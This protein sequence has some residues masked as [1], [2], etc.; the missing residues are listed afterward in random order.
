[1]TLPALREKALGSAGAEP[2]EPGKDSG[3]RGGLLAAS[4]ALCGSDP[5]LSR[6]ATLFEDR[7]PRV[8]HN[9]YRSAGLGGERHYVPLLIEKLGS[10][11]DRREAREA[12]ALYGDRIVG[13]L[14]DWL[15]DTSLPVAVRREIPRVLS[16]IGTQDAAYSLLRGADLREDRAVVHEVLRALNRIR[17]RDQALPAAVGGGRHL[18]PEIDL[19]LRLLVQRTSVRSI[20][21][22]AARTLLMHVLGEWIDQSLELIFRRLALLYPTREVLLAHRGAASSNARLRAQSLEVLDTILSAEHKGLLLPL[23]EDAP[24]EEKERRAARLLGLG[25]PS[26]RRTLQELIESEEPCI[27]A[28]EKQPAAVQRER[29][30]GL[31]PQS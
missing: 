24:A 6:L 29:D 19:Y 27:E 5:A 30:G 13:T 7:D 3:D 8:R 11:A 4:P 22:G 28:L 16:A 20:P 12:L 18:R 25:R 31:P 14:G 1:L 23:I 17:S 21:D 2:L 10:S 26:V 15:I 9:A